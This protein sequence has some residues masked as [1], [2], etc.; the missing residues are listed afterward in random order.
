MKCY[1]YIQGSDRVDASKRNTAHNGIWALPFGDVIADFIT[2]GNAI[3]LHEM[4]RQVGKRLWCAFSAI[5][6]RRWY[7]HGLFRYEDG[8]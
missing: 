4:A 2:G 6:D 3:C 1:I 7:S 8:D 5:D